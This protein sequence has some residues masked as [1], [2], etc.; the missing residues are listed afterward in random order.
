LL[1][2]APVF[3]LFLKELI[4]V[5]DK[6]TVLGAVHKR[7]A[8]RKKFPKKG[9]GGG[10]KR[11]MSVAA[12]SGSQR[13]MSV[14]GG[15]KEVKKGG[16]KTPK[17]VTK[18][19]KTTSTKVKMVTTLAGCKSAPPRREVW[20]RVSEPLRRGAHSGQRRIRN[21]SIARGDS[22]RFNRSVALSPES[23]ASVVSVQ[24]T[25]RGAVACSDGKSRQRT[26]RG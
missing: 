3:R 15:A 17:S 19:R 4:Q 21:P 9:K 11:R 20:S 16:G 10:P 14:A 2:T 8:A 25:G 5:N 1:R 13:R 18:L 6:V 12:R 23:G 26:E 22:S 7:Q 24:L